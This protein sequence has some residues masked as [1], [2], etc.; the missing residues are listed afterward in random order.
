[1]Y[2]DASLAP[3][4][5]VAKTKTTI[6]LTRRSLTWHMYIN[7]AMS[8]CISLSW[9]GTSTSSNLVNS[10]YHTLK[11]LVDIRKAAAGAYNFRQKAFTKTVFIQSG[12]NIFFT[13]SPFGNISFE[14]FSVEGHIDD[15]ILDGIL[16]HKGHTWIWSV[17]ARPVHAIN[18]TIAKFQLMY[19]GEDCSADHMTLSEPDRVIGHYCGNKQLWSVESCSNRVEIKMGLVSPGHTVVQILYQVIDKPPDGCLS[20]PFRHSTAGSGVFIIGKAISL[21]SPLVHKHSISWYIIVDRLKSI[22][23]KVHNFPFVMV[24]H[25]RFAKNTLRAYSHSVQQGVAE[26]EIVGFHATIVMEFLV[27]S[28]HK[29]HIEYKVIRNTIA[30]S[31]SHCKY[32]ITTNNGRNM[33]HFE[34]HKHNADSS[35]KV[36]G[37]TPLYCLLDLITDVPLRIEI[38]QIQFPS[39]N[40]EDCLNSG[41]IIYDEHQEGLKVFQP[42]IGPLCGREIER[43]LQLSP[44]RVITTLSRNEYFPAELTPAKD[45]K[46]VYIAFYSYAEDE[47]LFRA[48]IAHDLKCVGFF[49][50]C[51]YL[52]TPIEGTAGMGIDIPRSFLE[53]VV[54][55]ERQTLRINII[56]DVYF[57]ACLILQLFPV[58]NKL[59]TS[60]SIHINSIT[61]IRTKQSPHSFLEPITTELYYSTGSAIPCVGCYDKLVLFSVPYSNVTTLSGEQSQVFNGSIDLFYFPVSVTAPT[62]ARFVIKKRMFMGAVLKSNI[63]TYIGSE[64]AIV[65]VPWSTGFYRLAFQRRSFTLFGHKNLCFSPKCLLIQSPIL[66][67]E[68]CPFNFVVSYFKDDIP[69]HTW[70]LNKEYGSLVWLSKLETLFTIGI[71]FETTELNAACSR[72]NASQSVKLYF[73]YLPRHFLSEAEQVYNPRQPYCEVKVDDCRFG[74]CYH[75]HHPR[76]QQQSTWNEQKASCRL[77]NKTLPKIRDMEESNWIRSLI[78]IKDNKYVPQ[79]ISIFLDLY[80]QV[81]SFTML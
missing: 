67:P 62:A 21:D 28:I 45:G 36:P 39:N 38:E 10:T 9:D 81:G 75:F 7:A 59:V 18:L 55:G 27:S 15:A 31:T 30:S 35:R 65:N 5:N 78:N 70:H 79:Y 4:G 14:Q 48:S 40:S 24:Y 42:Q 8:F 34:A 32:A 58:P 69:Y 68:S 20:V 56:V 76:L 66:A 19:S 25:G 3:E 50:P 6:L 71:D 29:I 12:H 41:L 1:M 72:S 49:Q 26:Y 23:L 54:F 17:H 33:V 43:R 80:K 2:I 74:K 37:I 77:F 51:V 44:Q 60:C 57:R 22:S 13:R 53:F 61:D 16:Q 11:C 46:K 73:L 64:A 47:G 52:G 63:P